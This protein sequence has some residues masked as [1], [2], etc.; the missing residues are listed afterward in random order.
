[1]PENALMRRAI[2]S[3]IACAACSCATGLGPGAKLAPLWKP[4]ALGADANRLKIEPLNSV[5]RLG[6]SAHLRVLSTQAGTADCKTADGEALGGDAEGLAIPSPALAAP[7]EIVCKIGD[8]TARAQ[9]TFT[10]SKSLPV[11]DPYAGGVALFKL[12][13]LDEPWKEPVARKSVGLDTLDP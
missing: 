9:V 10:D 5:A 4:V 7:V 6:E 8:A 2:V 13:E 3:L 1:M 11:A 12:R